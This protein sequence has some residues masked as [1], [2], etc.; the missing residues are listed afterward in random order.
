MFISLTH[1]LCCLLYTGDDDERSVRRRRMPPRSQHGATSAE[2][3][4]DTGRP[5]GLFTEMESVMDAASGHLL[6]AE[7]LVD[8]SSPYDNS[9]I[10]RIVSASILPL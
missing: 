6:A 3:D 10:N 9:N 7:T 8:T 5:E 4:H 1:Q 2:I